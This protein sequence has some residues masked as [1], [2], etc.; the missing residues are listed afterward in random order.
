MLP[1]TGWTYC[2]AWQGP[3]PS[4]AVIGKVD[5]GRISLSGNATTQASGLRQSRFC[6]TGLLTVITS[7]LPVIQKERVFNSS[8]PRGLHRNDEVIFPSGLPNLLHAC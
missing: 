7:G 1:P 6:R 8:D 3:S 4:N 2:G 5:R